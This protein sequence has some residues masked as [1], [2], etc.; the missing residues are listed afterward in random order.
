V[1]KTVKGFGVRGQ[2]RRK[3]RSE[4]T[5][6]F[7]EHAWF[8]R[9]EH[10]E[11]FSWNIGKMSGYSGPTLGD[12][13]RVMKKAARTQN[14]LQAVYGKGKIPDEAYNSLRLLFRWEQRVLTRKLTITGLHG[15]GDKAHYRVREH[16]AT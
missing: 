12:V 2:D 5:G 16:P 6:N 13:L 11:L 9:S 7:E 15:A 14:Q 1:S 4:L 3:T 10:R 8:V